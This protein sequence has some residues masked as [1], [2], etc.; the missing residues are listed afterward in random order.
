MDSC[1]SSRQSSLH[2]LA[3]YTCPFLSFATHSVWTLPRRSQTNKRETQQKRSFEGTAFRI[4]RKRVCTRGEKFRG[5]EVALRHPAQPRIGSFCNQLY[6]VVLFPNVDAEFRPAVNRLG[7]FCA[8]LCVFELLWIWQ[9]LLHRPTSKTAKL[10]NKTIANFSAPELSYART[11]V[12]P[13]YDFFARFFYWYHYVFIPSLPIFL[14]FLSCVAL[15][16]ANKC[17]ESK[18]LRFVSKL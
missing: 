18:Q 17:E 13:F 3:W 11:A 10:R 8:R 5:Q 6:S 7:M 14:L 4:R 12:L 9:S 16:V 2:E 15:H 1:V